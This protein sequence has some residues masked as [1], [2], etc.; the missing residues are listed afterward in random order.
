M[1]LY[2]LLFWFVVPGLLLLWMANPLFWVGLASLRA[3]N[4]PRTAALGT[5]ACA[6]ASIPM[7]PI[8]SDSIVLDGPAA[9]LWCSG[10]FAWFASTALLAIIGLIGWLAPKLRA[11]PQFRL[12]SVMMAVAAVA[13]ALALWPHAFWVLKKLFKVPGF[14]VG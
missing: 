3:G 8:M 13:L 1:F 2:S 5:A 11:R 7:T 4:W 12:R 14:Y 10:Y 9:F 6:L